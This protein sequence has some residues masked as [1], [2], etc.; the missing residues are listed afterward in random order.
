MPA[1][2]ACP[3]R[4]SNAVRVASET[5]GATLNLV[6]RGLA[7]PFREQM[8]AGYRQRFGRPLDSWVCQVVDGA[9]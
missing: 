5:K 7:E 8:A 4:S 6:R 2:D 9:G 3:W 1:G